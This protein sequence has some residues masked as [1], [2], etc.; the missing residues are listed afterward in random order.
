MGVNCR[1]HAFKYTVKAADQAISSGN[2]GTGLLYL[3]YAQS[4]LKY[5]SELVILLRVA[6]TALFDMSPKYSLLKRFLQTPDKLSPPPFTPEDVMNYETLVND[7]TEAEAT[8][9][10]FGVDIIQTKSR[11]G[12]IHPIIILDTDLDEERTPCESNGAILL[13]LPSYSARHPRN[14]R[15]TC[16]IS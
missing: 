2:F 9:K 15:S 7:L 8:M 14:T 10:L 16:I 5:D 12:T 6:E 1:S 3:Q 4:M 11:S 13:A